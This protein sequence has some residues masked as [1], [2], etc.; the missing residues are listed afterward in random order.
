MPDI[1]SIVHFDEPE[2]AEVLAAGLGGLDA[3]APVVEAQR[4]RSAADLAVL[5]LVALPI[6][7]FLSKLGESLGESTGAGLAKLVNAAF[8]RLRGGAGRH[9]VLRDSVHGMDV[10]LAADLPPTAFEQLGTLKTAEAVRLRYDLRAGAWV[11]TGAP[12][13]PQP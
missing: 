10:E 12:V 7:G 11:A 8:A 9:I 3:P 1:V 2:A 5:V 6:H 4:S 13:D